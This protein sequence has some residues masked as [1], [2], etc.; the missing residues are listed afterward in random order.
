MKKL[1]HRTRILSLA[2]ALAL[3]AG[4][5]ADPAELMQRAE[6]SL[7]KGDPVRR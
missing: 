7:Q 6:A 4:C 2:V 1:T 3:A 5:S